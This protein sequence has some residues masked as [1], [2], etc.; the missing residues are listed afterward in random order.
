VL[1][2]AEEDF[3]PVNVSGLENTAYATGSEDVGHYAGCSLLKL[4]CSFA[5]K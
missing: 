4:K 3:G 1:K 2:A 5:A